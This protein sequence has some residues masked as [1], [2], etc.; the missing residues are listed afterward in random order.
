[1][2]NGTTVNMNEWKPIKIDPKNIVFKYNF[3]TDFFILNK[4]FGG[5]FLFVL[6]LGDCNG[7]L[8]QFENPDVPEINK[9]PFPDGFNPAT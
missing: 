3:K 1:M 8:L 9:T 7:A 5:Y 6:E 4:Y 2:V